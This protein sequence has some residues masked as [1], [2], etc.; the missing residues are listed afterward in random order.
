[1]EFPL[2]QLRALE[3]V[4]DHGTFDAAARALQVTPSAVSQRIRALEVEAGRVLVRR[5]KPVQVTESGEAVLR[6]ARQVALLEDDVAA[7]LAGS[8]PGV[9]GQAPAT[10]VPVV[11]NADSLATWIVPALVAA[12]GR[13]VLVEVLREDQEH[14]LGPLRDGTAV[15]AVTSVAEAV[16][17]CSVR[18]LGRMRYRPMATPELVR[19]WFP[20]GATPGALEAAPVVCFDRKDDLQDAYLRRRA[21]RRLDP[22]RHFIPSTA[23][24]TEAV[25]LGLGWGM[26]LDEHGAGLERSGELVRIDD[27]HLDVP[28]FWQQWRIDTPSLTALAEEVAG[29]AAHLR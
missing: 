3:A 29:A 12:A 13:G 11:V 8:R 10:R 5:V 26:I 25:R 4:A 6:L 17:G 24:Y 14:S 2:H 27:R 18:R 15:A 28:L 16:Q 19:R 20:E 23:D 1:M 21:R 22:P 7:M 9:E